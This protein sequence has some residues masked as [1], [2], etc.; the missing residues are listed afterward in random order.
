MDDL[1]LSTL[2][3]NTRDLHRLLDGQ[4]RDVDEPFEVGGLKADTPGMFG[5]PAEDCNCR[6]CLL[7]RARWALDDVELETL[8][9]RAEY[10]GLD[11]TKDFEE[12]QTKYF[13]VSFQIEH[14]KCRF[15]KHMLHRSQII[16]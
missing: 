14:E 13:K 5:D 1:R 16:L 4:I 3:G 7:Q 9:K 2:D 15:V 10:F 8:R 6:C 12:Y 11:K